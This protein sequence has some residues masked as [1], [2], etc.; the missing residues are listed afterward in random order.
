MPE[1]PPQT[2]GTPQYS[3]RRSASGPS[4]DEDLP[5]IKVKFPDQ[6][7]YT[8]PVCDSQ[9]A[10]F[11]SW[12]RHLRNKHDLQSPLVFICSGCNLEFTSKKSATSH[13]NKE[14][15]P[16][17][18]MGRA[19]RTSLSAG[20]YL[21]DF[22]QEKFPNKR[23]KSQHI[24]NAHAD[25]ASEQRDLQAT[26][27]TSRYW[28]DAEHT[29]FLEALVRHGPSSN[30]VISKAVG[31]KTAK[32]VSMHKRTFLRDNP[33]WLEKAR[34]SV[35][36]PSPGPPA[37]SLSS[38]SSRPTSPDPPATS[39]TILLTAP[40][41]SPSSHP[42]TTSPDRVPPMST[43]D[44]IPSVVSS[45]NMSPDVLNNNNNNNNNVT[46]DPPPLSAPGISPVSSHPDPAAPHSDLSAPSPIAETQVNL[47]LDALTPLRDKTLSDEEW[48]LFETVLSS[49]VDN[50]P[51]WWDNSSPSHFSTSCRQKG[52]QHWNK[53]R[54]RRQGAAHQQDTTHPQNGQA[55]SEETIVT[56]PRRHRRDRAR[57]AKVLQAEYRKN[58]KKC[59]R[60]IVNKDGPIYCRIPKD[61]LEAHFNKS[62]HTSSP[63]PPEWLPSGKAT[64]S[65]DLT[66]KVSKEEITAQLKRLPSESSPG[67]DRLSYRFWKNLPRSDS[68]LAEIINICLKNNRIPG[69]WK[70]SLTVLIYKK[71]DHK[72]PS[73]WRPISLQCTIYKIFTAVLARR[74]AEFCIEGNIISPFQKGFMPYEGCFEHTFMMTSLLEDSKRNCKDL[75]TVWF[76]LENA[77]GSVL[78]SVLFDM[79]SRLE[80]PN[81]FIS[82]CK[83]IYSG[84]LSRIRTGSG[85]T[86]TIPLRMGV[87]QG[88]PLSPLLFNL[89]LQG[90][91][92]GLDGVEGGYKMSSTLIVKYLAYADD[93]CIVA[94][95]KDEVSAFIS[96]MEEFMDWAGLSFN[97][98]KCASL[99][100]INSSPHKYVQSFSPL[101]KGKPVRALKWSE[102]YRYL[103]VETGRTGI[104][105]LDA[106]RQ[107]LVNE[108]S[109]IC[110]SLLTDWQKI[111]AINTFVISKATYYLRA[112]LP[113]LGWVRQIDKEIRS[114][115][116]KGL[117]LPRRTIS[118]VIY[119]KRCVGGLGLFCLE[120]NLQVAR[121][122]QMC[123][124]L[125]S[126]DSA[127]RNCAWSQL[128]QTVSCR[129]HKN[130]TNSDL[131]LFLNSPIPI[132]ERQT[133]DVKSLWSDARKSLEQMGLKVDLTRESPALVAAD[134]ESFLANDRQPL[135]TSFAVL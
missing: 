33:G 113:T 132:E 103:G 12:T 91:L 40:S 60:S 25:K 31:S 133:R 73:N 102:R 34:V 13:Y 85:Y 10:I 111:D 81:S 7:V 16:S 107:T 126:P 112:A 84:S 105:N 17:G 115:V 117:Q 123:R 23:S 11:S 78:H 46:P 43:P 45:T 18:P 68:L 62:P 101:I 20:N 39:S 27:S 131:E 93:L 2:L 119:T 95:S 28:T 24:R 90:M 4:C 128:R 125:T 72:D 57:R 14:H 89:V 88:C 56:G 59:F 80:I 82:L 86:D 134:G 47:L 104:A 99:S 58:R 83:D 61:H 87:K 22:C 50:C 110:S 109:A 55:T 118:H 79:M 74:L 66:S 44:H 100:C 15:G 6:T 42:P 71:G 92:H 127:I 65:D 120:D 94:S 98:Q 70:E 124:C 130:P 49:W 36:P 52:A 21:C 129:G 5:V 30:I 1:I 9:Y 19:E 69:P 29:L 32:Q 96:K 63:P 75:Y 53:R 41:S 116:K 54:H 37:V 8:C 135:T 64:E 121:L 106:L 97:V 38:P 35:P 26:T 77:F 76:D 51:T 114:A 122:T 67:P 108:T 48:L 3:G